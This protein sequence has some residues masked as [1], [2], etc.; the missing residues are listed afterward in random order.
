ML[1]VGG[2][3]YNKAQAATFDTVVQDIK[4][5]THFTAFEPNVTTSYL[6]NARD[7]RNEGALTK[8]V[9]VYRCLSSDIGIS[10]GYDDK[11]RGSFI[12]GGQLHIGDLLK[13][14][15]PSLL[16]TLSALSPDALN[17]L[18][19]K[20]RFGPVAGYSVTDDKW[21]Y[22]IIAGFSWSF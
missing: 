21:V 2:L 5:N 14:Q 3:T 18:I 12:A 19:D 8:S 4:D 7:G 17:N 6:F 13:W 1:L 22:G 16:Q 15:F 20:A 10:S 9:L 11:S